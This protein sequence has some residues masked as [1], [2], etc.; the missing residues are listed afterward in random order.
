MKFETWEV[1]QSP[2]IIY[3]IQKR[4]YREEIHVR[5]IRRENILMGLIKGK[6]NVPLSLEE[7]R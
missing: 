1:I 5:E 6:N 2:S 7:N 3:P 4:E